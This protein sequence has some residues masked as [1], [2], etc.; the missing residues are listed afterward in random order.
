[1]ILQEK[2]GK[3]SDMFIIAKVL[4]EHFSIMISDIVDFCDINESEINSLPDSSRIT[5]YSSS[6]LWKSREV[7][8]IDINAILERIEA[9]LRNE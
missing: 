7:L 6:F 4:G 1:M 3:N 9:D 2:E 5:C 8:V